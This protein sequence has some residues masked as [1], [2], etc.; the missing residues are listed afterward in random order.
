MT[1][2]F[3]ALRFQQCAWSSRFVAP[4]SIP[5][6]IRTKKT[7][8]KQEPGAVRSK[9]GQEDQPRGGK[10]YLENG[11]KEQSVLWTDLAS[12]QVALEQKSAA[13]LSPSAPLRVSSLQLRM[14]TNS[15]GRPSAED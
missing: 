11:T 15:H 5:G 10:E 9:P 2:A 8:E 14:R 6:H 12:A 3:R 1:A 7:E 13:R 4:V